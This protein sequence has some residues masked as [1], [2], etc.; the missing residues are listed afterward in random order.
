MQVSSTGQKLNRVLVSTLLIIFVGTALAQSARQSAA[1]QIFDLTNQDR[2]AE[3][4]PPL[5]WNAALADAAQRH[6]ELM[7]RKGNISHQYP[8]EPELMQRAVEVGAHFRAI[9]ENVAMAPTAPDVE[10][11][12]MHSTPHRT[13]ILDPKMNVLGVGVA[14]R[15]PN[16]YAVE[17]FAAAST[18]LKPEQVE[19]RVR[20]MLR[21]DGIDASASAETAREACA[22]QRGM[23][24]GVNAL[25]LRMQAPDLQQLQSQIEQQARARHFERAEVGACAPIGQGQFT[26]YRVAVL[27]F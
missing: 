21:E 6:A 9:A 3:G 19:E 20:A 1:R 24:R 16:I 13:N 2:R 22:M 11:A 10:I 14:V 27:L 8:G 15:G 18:A 23:P 17:D 4:L 12:W 25:M 7:A 26:V 5:E